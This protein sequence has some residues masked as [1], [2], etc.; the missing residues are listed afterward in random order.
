[1][2]ETKEYQLFIDGKWITSTSGF[3]DGKHGFKQYLEKET[4]YVRHKA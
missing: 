1:M 3:E 2:T 4:V